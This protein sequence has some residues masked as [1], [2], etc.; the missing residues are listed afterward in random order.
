MLADLDTGL[1]LTLMSVSLFT[2]TK[3][4]LEHSQK[5]L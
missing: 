4:M 1:L 5:A 2:T 3:P